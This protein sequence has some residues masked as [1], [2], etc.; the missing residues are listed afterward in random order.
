[1]DIDFNTLDTGE[2]LSKDSHSAVR[3]SA[4]AELRKLARIF[5]RTYGGKTNLFISKEAAN[6][7]KQDVYNARLY[8][9]LHI[10]RNPKLAIQT[11]PLKQT[12][13]NVYAHVEYNDKMTSIKLGKKDILQVK[14][15]LK[16]L[17]MYKK[18]SCVYVKDV[19]ALVLDHYQKNRI[20]ELEEA[21]KLT[22]TLLADGNLDYNGN[23]F[24][25]GSRDYVAKDNKNSKIRHGVVD[26]LAEVLKEITN[27]NTTV[28]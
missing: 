20:Q 23:L 7:I 13:T 19:V 27:A 8:T 5:E 26:K 25:K 12:W 2:D 15:L 21:Q 11:Y 4:E 28:R 6:P 17:G 14:K 22:L 18:F 9:L 24:I 16:E 1:M 10:I 3:A